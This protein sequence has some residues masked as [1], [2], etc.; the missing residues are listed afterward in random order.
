MTYARFALVALAATVAAAPRAHGQNGQGLTLTMTSTMNS[1]Q[2]KTPAVF[3]IVKMQISS[4]GKARADFLGDGSTPA[5]TTPGT[6]QNPADPNRPPLLKAGTYSLGRK[7]NDT[8][9]IVDPS[10][11]KMWVMLRSDA[12]ATQAAA[13]H[14]INEQYTDVS[15]TTQR[16]TPDSTIEGITV[17]HWRILD[18]HTMKS[19]IMGTTNSTIAK[20]VYDFYTAPDYDMG[21]ASQMSSSIAA[22]GGADTAYGNKLHAALAQAMK[23]L[24]L[25]MQTQMQMLDN[26]GKT[27]SFSMAMRASNV[28]HG[29][30]PAGVYA[31]PSGYTTVRGSFGTPPTAQP[32]VSPVAGMTVPKGD[33]THKPS[34]DSAIGKQLGTDVT[35]GANNAV[36]QKIHNAIHFP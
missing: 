28:S 8:S 29:D 9:L 34:L 16:I 13:Q 19:H 17:Q 32:T 35:N 23:G 7:G 24:P 33:T 10:Q 36:Q 14:M 3:S 30:P 22:A 21:L 12:A 15:V 26:K 25:L 18:S 20:M 5:A 4:S 27:T 2:M 6:P 31:V 1:S 11:K